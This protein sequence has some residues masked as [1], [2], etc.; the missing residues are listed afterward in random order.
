LLFVLNQFVRIEPQLLGGRPL[1]SH[2]DPFVH[3][4]L[5]C[6]M[7]T[8]VPLILAAIFPGQTDGPEEDHALAVDRGKERHRDNITG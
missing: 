1:L 4:V 7:R 2:T 6:F 8:P 3:G 5:R